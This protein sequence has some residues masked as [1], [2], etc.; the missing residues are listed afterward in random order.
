MGC[1]VVGVFC[2]IFNP[3]NVLAHVSHIEIGVCDTDGLLLL[4]NSPNIGKIDQI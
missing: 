4:P 1:F 2:F 3:V